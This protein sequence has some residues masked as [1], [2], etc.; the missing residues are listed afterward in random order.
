MNSNTVCIPVN[1]NA[2]TVNVTGP[3]GIRCC[4]DE[5]VVKRAVSSLSCDVLDW[6]VWPGS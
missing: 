1:A 6:C 2:S 4:G 3:L 5:D